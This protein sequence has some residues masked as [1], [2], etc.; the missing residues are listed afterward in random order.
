MT[1]HELSDLLARREA[2]WE[3]L[4]YT[5]LFL[6]DM[7]PERRARTDRASLAFRAADRAIV[8]ELRRRMEPVAVGG[9]ELH[10]TAD[11]LGFAVVDPTTGR[12]PH[13]DAYRRNPAYDKSLLY[14]Y[15]APAGGRRV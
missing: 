14:R 7:P 12:C 4:G 11:G 3:E 1:T 13:G 6:R 2:A 10:L 9:V 15:P 5:T 8:A